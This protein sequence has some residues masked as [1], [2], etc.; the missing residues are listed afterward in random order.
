MLWGPVLWDAAFLQ[1]ANQGRLELESVRAL[2]HCCH[3]GMLAGFR[4]LVL[5]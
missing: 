3:S 4:L 1:I 5:G 2:V